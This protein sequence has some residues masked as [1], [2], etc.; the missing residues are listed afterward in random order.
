MNIS[1]PK[2]QPK[3]CETAAL[4]LINHFECN[5]YQLNCTV[6]AIII[7]NNQII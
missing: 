3:S 1:P 6:K 2:C 7:N 4:T 5:S